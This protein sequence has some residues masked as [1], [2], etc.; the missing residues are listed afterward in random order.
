VKQK[1]PNYVRRF[2]IAALAVLLVSALC[3]VGLATDSS[4]PTKEVQECYKLGDMNSDGVITDRDAVYLMYHIHF[5]EDYPIHGDGNLDGIGNCDHKD[6]IYILYATFGDTTELEQVV[7]SY[8]ESYWIW[9][10]D[11][12]KVTAQHVTDCTCHEASITKNAVVTEEVQPADC[13]SAGQTVW[14]AVVEGQEP[15]TKTQEIPALG[16]DMGGNATCLEPKHCLRP[17]CDHKEGEALGH[18]WELTGT[19]PATCQKEGVE[20]YTCSACQ[21][22]SEVILGL[23]DHSFLRV[24]ELDQ[25]VLVEGTTCTYHIQFT[26]K[27]S[28]EGC[29]ETK[30][31]FSDEEYDKH[32]YGDAVLTAAATCMAAGKKTYTCTECEQYYSVEI[33]VDTAAHNW[34]A[35]ASTEEVVTHTC[36]NEGCEATKT[37]VVV[38]SNQAVS[39]EQLKGNELQL[40]NE[41]TETGETVSAALTM[42]EETLDALD[43]E[44]ELKISVEKVEDSVIDDLLTEE[45]KAQLD[46]GIVYDFN[47]VYSVEGEEDEPITEFEGK[48]TVSLPYELEEGEDPENIAVW[49]INDDD[50]TVTSIQAKYNNGFITF[51]TDHFSYYTVTRLTPAERC[52][53]YGHLELV[54][55]NKTVTCTEDGYHIETCP[56]CSEDV[57]NEIYPHAGHAYVTNSIKETCENGGQ[58]TKTCSVCQHEISA[59]I[60]AMGHNMQLDASSKAAS[61]TENGQN[62]YKCANGCGREITEELPATGHNFKLTAEQKADCTNNG[63]KDYECANGCGEKFSEVTEGFT[64]HLYNDENAVW[65]WTVD[66]NGKPSATCV[67]RCAYNLDNEKHWHELKKITITSSTEGVSCTT[68]GKTVYTATASYNAKVTF[69]STYEM[70]APARGHIPATEWSQDTG[71]HYRLCAVC[72]AELKREAHIMI[73]DE[74]LKEATCVDAGEAST[75]CSECGYEGTKVLPATGI[76][77]YDR[78]GVCRVCGRSE[79]DCSHYRVYSS[80]ID[81]SSYDLC[82]GV[83]IWQEACECGYDSYISTVFVQCD[84]ED[85]A[86]RTEISEEGRE[87]TVTAIQC[88]N[89][90]VIV[91]TGNCTITDEETCTTHYA[92]YRA[93]IIGDEV[94]GGKVAVSEDPGELHAITEYETIVLTPEEHGLCQT[95]ILVGSCSCGERKYYEVQNT[96]CDLHEAS[97]GGFGHNERCSKCDSFWKYMYSQVTEDGCCVWTTNTLEI[98]VENESILFAENNRLEEYHVYQL[99]DSELFGA[100]CE[101]RALAVLECR[102]CDRSI[103]QLVDSHDQMFITDVIDMSEHG[104][105]FD[106][107]VQLSCV[108]GQKQ[109]IE[110]D[111]VRENYCDWRILDADGYLQEC[112]NCGMIKRIDRQILNTDDPCSHIIHDTV[113]YSDSEGNELASGISRYT[114][115]EHNMVDSYELLG[116]SCEDGVVVTKTCVICGDTHTETCYY[117]V[118]STWTTYDLSAIGCCSDRDVV[119]TCPCEMGNRVDEYADEGDSCYWEEVFWDDFQS[120]SYCSGCGTTRTVKSVKGDAVDSCHTYWTV[121]YTFSRNDEDLLS[122]SYDRIHTAHEYYNVYEMVE[123][124]KTCADGYY[125]EERCRNCDYVYR[126]DYVRY[127]SCDWGDLIDVTVYSDERM[128]GD[129]MVSTYSCACGQYFR[130]DTE[131]VNGECVYTDYTYDGK[132]GTETAVCENCGVRYTLSVHHAMKEGHSCIQVETVDFTFTHGNSELFSFTRT[133]HN[134]FHSYYTEFEMFGESCADGYHAYTVCRECGRIWNDSYYD[135]DNCENSFVLDSEVILDGSNICGKLVKE[136]VGCACGK[137]VSSQIIESYHTSNEY[138]GTDD[139]G[140]DIFECYACGLIERRKE[141]V[142]YSQNSCEYEV[143]TQYEYWLNGEVIGETSTHHTGRSHLYTY[144]FADFTGNCDD[145]YTIIETCI[146]CGETWEGTAYGCSYWQTEVDPIHLSESCGWTTLVHE[147]CPCGNNDNRAL[148]TCAQNHVGSDGDWDIYECSRCDLIR[149]TRSTSGS[150]VDSCEVV[151]HYEHVFELNGEVVDTVTVDQVTGYNHVNIVTTVNKLGDDCIDGY[152]VSGECFFCGETYTDDTVYYGCQIFPTAMEVMCDAEDAC[153]KFYAVY[154]GC[155]CCERIEGAMLLHSCNVTTVSSTEVDGVT[156]T[157]YLC[158]ECGMETTEVVTR[159]SVENSCEIL[160]T[161]DLTYKMNGQV[162]DTA[163][164]Y[165]YDR[166][167]HKYVYDLEAKGVDCSMGYTGTGKCYYCGDTCSVSGNGCATYL[168]NYQEVSAEGSCGTYILEITNCACGTHINMKETDPCLETRETIHSESNG[169]TAVEYCRC[170]ECGMETRVNMRSGLLSERCFLGV[171]MDFDWSWEGAVISEYSYEIAFAWDHKTVY[172][173]EMRGESLFTDGCDLYAHCQ[174]CGMDMGHLAI[175]YSYEPYPVEFVQISDDVSICGGRFGYYL[176]AYPDGTPAAPELTNTCSNLT[177]STNGVTGAIV[178]TCNDCGLVIEGSSTDSWDRGTHDHYYTW[179]YTF[180]KNDQTIGAVNEKFHFVNHEAVYD[181]ELLGEDCEDG[182]L[183]YGVCAFCDF[184]MQLPDVG[185]GHQVVPVDIIDLAALGVCGEDAHYV[186]FS[187]ACKE[188]A[189]FDG[190]QQGCVLGE[191]TEDMVQEGDTIIH[192]MSAPCTNPGCASIMQTQQVTFIQPEGGCKSYVRM[193]Y[194]FTLADGSKVSVYNNDVIAEHKGELVTTYE[195]LD[196]VSC[197]GGVQETTVCTSCNEVASSETYYECRTH[198]IEQID[199]S[200]LGAT[201]GGYLAKSECTCGTVSIYEVVDL[202]CNLEETAVDLFVDNAIEE[203]YY[204]TVEGQIYVSNTASVLSCTVEGCDFSVRAANYWAKE[205]CKLVNYGITQ[206]GYDAATGKYELELISTLNTKE[207]HPNESLHT[208]REL[209]EYSDYCYQGAWLITMC[210]DCGQEISRSDYYYCETFPQ[211]DPIDLSQYGSHCGGYLAK[212]DCL[213]GQADPETIYSFHDLKCDLDKDEIAHFV[214]GTLDEVYCETT[215]GTNWLYSDSYLYTCAVNNPYVCGM[216]IRYSRCWLQEG[217]YAVEY[218]VWQLDYDSDTNTWADEIRIP[219]GNKRTFHPYEWSNPVGDIEGGYTLGSRYDCPLCGSYYLYLDY[220]LYTDDSNTSVTNDRAERIAVNMLDNGEPLRTRQYYEYMQH[221]GLNNYVYSLQTFSRHEV[222]YA[223]GEEYWYQYEYEYDFTGECKKTTYYT[224]SN[225]ASSEYEGNGH[226]TSQEHIPEPAPTCGRFGKT[227]IVNTCLFCGTVTEEWEQINEPTDHDWYW[228]NVKQLYECS[229]CGLENGSAAIGSID[230]SGAIVLED[231]TD[232]LGN[233]TDYVVAYWNRGNIDYSLYINV[234]MNDITDGDN[235]AWLQVAVS[236]EPYGEYGTN[237]IRFN[238]AEAEASAQAVMAER[239]YTGDY[240]IRLTFAPTGIGHELDYSITFDDTEEVPCDH[241]VVCGYDH[242]TGNCNDGYSVIEYCALCG[243]VSNEYWT[244]GCYSR[245]MEATPVYYSETCGW[246]YIGYGSCPC[247]NYEEIF[248]VGCAYGNPIANDGPYELS[249]C[250]TCGM[251][252]KAR[253]SAEYEEDS[254]AC[255]LHCEVLVGMNGESVAA[256]EED[257][258]IRIHVISCEFENFTGNCDDGYTVKER[259][260]LCGINRTYGYTGCAGHSTDVTLLYQSETCGW[261]YGYHVKCPCGRYDDEYCSTGCNWDWQGSNDG[262]DTYKCSRCGTIRK[263]HG[264]ETEW[265]DQCHY[266]SGCDIVFEQ[267]GVE[268]GTAREKYTNSQHLYVTEFEDF[269]GNCDDSYRI[270]RTCI[271]C[272]QTESWT[273][274]GCACWLTEITPI[275][276]SETCG[277]TY[278]SHEGCPCGSLENEGIVSGCAWNYMGTEDGWDIYCCINCGLT[279]KIRNYTESIPDSCEVINGSE[280]VFELNGEILYT[281]KN[282]SISHNHYYYVADVVRMGEDCSDGYTV[283]GKCYFCNEL[284]YDETVYYGCDEFPLQIQV[285][286]DAEDACGN[287]YAVYGGCP[288]C[289]KISNVVDVSFCSFV[290]I[291]D[292]NNTFIGRACS[293]CGL[294]ETIVETQSPSENSC[295]T[296]VILDLTYRMEGQIVDTATIQFVIGTQHKYVYELTANGTTCDA[297]YTAV[298]TCYYCGDR[299]TETGYGCTTYLVGYQTVNQAGSCGVNT[300][301]VYNC[302]CG[303]SLHDAV[304]YSCHL[305]MIDGEYDEYGNGVE[306]HACTECGMEVQIIGTFGLINDTCGMGYVLNF[307]W[308]WEGQTIAHYDLEFVECTDHKLVYAFNMLGD[309]LF[310]DGCELYAHCDLCGMDMGYQGTTYEYRDYPVE[311]VHLSDTVNTCGGGRLGYYL[312]Q[313]PNGD[314]LGTKLSTTCSNWNQTTDAET[315]ET[316]KTCT[317]CGLVEIGSM[318]ETMGERPQ[319]C[320]ATRTLDYVYQLNGITLGEVKGDFAFTQHAESYSF[321]MLGEDCDDG[322]FVY[323]TCPFCDI[324]IQVPGGAYYGHT[325]SPTAYYLLTDMGICP[326][327][328]AAY[329]VQ[330]NC[331]CM[332]LANVDF[333]IGCSIEIISETLDEENPAHMTHTLTGRCTNADCTT[334]LHSIYDTYTRSEDSCEAFIRSTYILEFADGTKIELHDNRVE[335]VHDTTISYTLAEGA[336][337]CS[338]GA[339][340]N[341]SCSACGNVLSSRLYYGCETHPVEQID[342]SEHGS[343]CG[344]YVVKSECACGAVITHEIAETNCSLVDAECELFVTD[345]VAE[346]TYATANGNIDVINEAFMVTCEN[347]GCDFAFRVANYWMLEDG[348]L[349]NYET[350]QLGYDPTTGVY[351][352]E[353]ISR[354]NEVVCLSS[355]PIATTTALADKAKRYTI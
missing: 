101:D 149:K 251:T 111:S 288:C 299:H 33:P 192:T 240:A 159:S 45:Q 205:G 349:V 28:A 319:L 186:Q 67:L 208:Y 31:A 138:M 235:E 60:P 123:G 187:C 243:K 165:A 94:L 252:C 102:F 293:V 174:M 315:G 220:F 51:E 112:A 114:V 171:H 195:L 7:H 104:A 63:H 108:C 285:L 223:N 219:T 92:Q 134:G 226:L 8:S 180:R 322:Y 281:D 170:T 215:N 352:T 311:Y 197:A 211:E 127:G 126:Y 21:E 50:G 163:T 217:C 167:N 198:Q 326:Y 234:V 89:C 276:W 232:E 181:F 351:D 41:N 161:V 37:T 177:T 125:Q 345:A 247:G 269:T 190:V 331:P 286:C 273:S 34:I 266:T 22:T 136:T 294:E 355:E 43:P 246:T 259:C 209:M 244:S 341:T 1:S 204:D 330:Y 280:T 155:P 231:L 183:V 325:A 291:I 261:T 239:G 272:G 344:G 354:L 10:E 71:T 65:T 255:I 103:E 49:Y 15:V 107:L 340:E 271:T 56:R 320:A 46:G 151:T 284:Y 283:S 4:E 23:A 139:E 2:L 212:M 142:T 5:P 9:G 30:H 93:V 69:T 47:M 59:T 128:C 191:I 275:N 312:L 164:A 172:T 3:V 188:Y 132:T 258:K 279:K 308:N 248:R 337:T 98:F 74:I 194:T 116:D 179:D 305:E 228:N 58:I 118:E 224:D 262:L 120:V 270:T 202:N 106:E 347:E 185:Y 307:T 329:A 278:W 229:V 173:F 70:D 53:T 29:Q 110:E 334:V 145:G 328:G 166:T 109:Q 62:V 317:A 143:Y 178:T 335:A 16:H 153:G 144:E 206:F 168:V 175:I 298:G 140:W 289:G 260:V 267:N 12:G 264:I 44:K 236:D 338:G 137:N 87:Y 290:D 91:E 19:T 292:A 263:L 61:C 154:V 348:K 135:G 249:A 213:C 295:D 105:C 90:G 182:Y 256:V 203:G 304:D 48:V 297:G 76:H 117:H 13:M 26:Y 11:D 346:G 257:I 350:V 318:T 64:G 310:V 254:C 119:I 73:D 323:A 300:C 122:F 314:P 268:V 83:R 184:R 277:W 99:V 146:L 242:F 250:E 77:D 86:P 95:T 68:A 196:G 324:R 296:L 327:N 85:L 133:T 227:R 353:L 24:T 75:V 100:S 96:D 157:V 189:G 80:E 238:I 27:C 147:E 162:V 336:T 316:T 97:A 79:S 88:K 72:N 306:H 160:I 241:L 18:R 20:H 309:S 52:A 176:M 301:A 152:T 274:T 124:A 148:W 225:G 115:T 39:T 17:E 253:I 237:L 201:C 333:V 207:Y 222:T 302:A 282:E 287:V 200:E 214:E 158:Q 129:M 141:T 84:F 199:M 32:T 343:V 54:E 218:E 25:E 342:M 121:T 130:Q 40:T 233:G 313:A 38:V 78:Y 156:T 230:G 221:K 245:I 193:T 81:L 321:D 66:E 339:Y 150:V 332:R 42:D 113:T 35:A 210:T 303:Q 169:N 14:T 55:K 6:A 36:G 216:K 265:V 82:A 57:V 131:W